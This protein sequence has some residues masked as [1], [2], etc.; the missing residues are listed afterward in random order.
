MVFATAAPVFAQQP[1]EDG[2]PLTNE[3]SVKAKKNAPARGVE[4]GTLFGFSHLRP[5]SV[6]SQYGPT[7]IEVPG[8]SLLS[9]RAHT[10]YVS[11]F[12]SEWLAIRPEFSLSQ[13]LDDA[14]KDTFLYLGGQGAFFPQ[15]NATSGPYILGRVG[16]SIQSV[17]NHSETVFS[18]GAG[19]GYRWC[20]GPA[21]VLR[22]EARYQRLF[23]EGFD[24]SVGAGLEY[25]WCIGPAFVVRTEVRYQRLFGEGFDENGA[26]GFSIIFGLGTKVGHVNPEQKHSAPEVEIGTLFGLS[27]FRPLAPW[28]DYAITTIGVPEQSTLPLGDYTFYI[29]WFPSEQLAIGP[30]FNLERDSRGGNSTTSFYF[31]GQGTF[32][33]Q[34]NAMSGPYILGRS[35]LLRSFYN[36][37]ERKLIVGAGLGYRWHLGT[38]FVLRTEARYQRLFFEEG[39][40]IF[41]LLIG[42]GTRLGGR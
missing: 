6:T 33:L 39:A 19:L 10:L 40:N 31:G 17:Y 7:M 35:G 11:W 25:R 30:E 22:A 13:F 37:P 20:I 2:L 12:P 8:T 5:F 18:V 34:S 26:N 9:L 24:D 28:D 15:R 36:D 3:E 42:I 23:G 38:A 1:I 29:S 41:S 21:S 32:F 27:H 14:D 4:I 16:L